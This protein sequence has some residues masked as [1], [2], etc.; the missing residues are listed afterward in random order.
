MGFVAT[1]VIGSS[2]QDW[3]HK[4]TNSRPK[5]YFDKTSFVPFWA[6]IRGDNSL[7]ETVKELRWGVVLPAAVAIVGILYRRF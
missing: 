4:V 5:E 3:R 2:H 1:W 6:I 7:A